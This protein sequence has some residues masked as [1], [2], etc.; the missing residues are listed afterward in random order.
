MALVPCPECDKQ[1]SDAATA[2]PSCG[3]PMQEIAVQKT[4]TPTATSKEL[5]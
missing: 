4:E 1:I 2:F 5:F 3:H